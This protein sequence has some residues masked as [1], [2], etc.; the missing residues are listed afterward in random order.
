LIFVNGR[1]WSSAEAWPRVN[2]PVPFVEDVVTPPRLVYVAHV[3]FNP[4]DDDRYDGVRPDVGLLR[5][6]LEP[7]VDWWQR[8]D[9]PVWIGESGV[10]NTPEWAALLDC[11][12]VLY[13]EPLG[14]GHLYWEYSEWS[15]DQ[16]R[17]GA[18]SL[19][20]LQRHLAAPPRQASEAPA[21]S[22][23]SLS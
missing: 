20:A 16:T 3:Y 15:R 17:L 14:W 8:N 2:G 7:L 10:P 4:G 19:A 18:F 22:C 5:Q 1:S 12:F 11:A 9:V 13:Y 21:P 23:D 6:R